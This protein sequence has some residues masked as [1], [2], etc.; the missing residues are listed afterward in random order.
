MKIT[1]SA[2]PGW[3]P[4]PSPAATMIVRQP[5]APPA[6]VAQRPGNCE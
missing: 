4:A 1:A 2:A 6:A 5:N 3:S